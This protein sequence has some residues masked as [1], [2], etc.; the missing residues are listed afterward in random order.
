MVVGLVNGLNKKALVD[1]TKAL[2]NCVK[3]IKNDFDA[4]LLLSRA[5]IRELVVYQVAN[6]SFY[7][8][9]I[10]EHTTG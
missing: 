4:R 7:D 8:I 9:V 2:C 3:A 5:T 6:Y 1:Q 10:E